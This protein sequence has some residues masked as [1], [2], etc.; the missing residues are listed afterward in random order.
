M[1]TTTNKFPKSMQSCWVKRKFE[2][3]IQQVKEMGLFHEEVIEQQM[4]QPET[5]KELTRDEMI[6]RSLSDA[7]SYANCEP[8][9]LSFGDF[10]R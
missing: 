5:K 2:E 6:D 3:L 1:N 4:E 10:E 9:Q 8:V 7:F